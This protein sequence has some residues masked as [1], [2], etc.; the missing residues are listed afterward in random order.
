MI[1]AIANRLPGSVSY[2]AHAVTLAP[3]RRTYGFAVFKRFRTEA[4]LGQ[5]DAIPTCPSRS[6]AVEIDEL[7]EEG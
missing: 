5:D 4:G 2:T 1:C 3:E 6:P 7:K